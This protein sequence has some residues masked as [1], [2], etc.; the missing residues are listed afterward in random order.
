MIKSF[1]YV[2]QA[3]AVRLNGPNLEMPDVVHASQLGR[4][5]SRLGEGRVV[6]DAH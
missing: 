6:A 2:I 1:D 4:D 5:L 3:T